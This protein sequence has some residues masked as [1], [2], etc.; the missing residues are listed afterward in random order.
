MKE[1]FTFGK[2]EEKKF[3][4]TGL[5]IEETNDGI[6]VDQND[7]IQSLQPIKIDKLAGKE[8]KLSKEKFAE[9]RGLT[10]QLSWAAENTRPDLSFD[11]RELSTKNKEAT[12]D[13]LKHANK[14]LKKAQLEK[15][16]SLRFTKLGKLEN[17][18]IVVYTDSSYRNAENKEKSVGGRLVVLAN[19]T[20][21]CN[22]LLWKSKTIQ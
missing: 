10:G 21:E 9:F 17:L 3:K 19:K 14:V 4:F 5:N 7:Y 8:E 6:L 12:Y 22:P 2:T 18:K 15:D 11:A 1:R 13:D 16:V 20:G